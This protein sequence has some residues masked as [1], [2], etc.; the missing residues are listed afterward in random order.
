MYA[1]VSV[2]AQNVSPDSSGLPGMNVVSRIVGGLLYAGFFLA[3]ATLV[4]AAIVWAA[5]SIGG[6]YQG[7]SKGKT[8]VAVSAVAALLL[9]GASAIVRFF[10][11]MGGSIS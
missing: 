8:G 7:V 5:S 11:D 9:G 1:I 10:V 3:V 4:V 6:N 2:I